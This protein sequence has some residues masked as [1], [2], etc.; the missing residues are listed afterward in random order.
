M[1]ILYNTQKRT[2]QGLLKVE[3]TFINYKAALTAVHSQQYHFGRLPYKLYQRNPDNSL[4][5][6]PLLK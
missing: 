4:T 1:Y 3:D 6:V 5:E 2:K